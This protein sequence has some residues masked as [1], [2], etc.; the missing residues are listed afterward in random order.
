[1]HLHQQRPISRRSDQSGSHP[2]PSESSADAVIDESGES[3]ILPER[4]ISASINDND[5]TPT[6]DSI[7]N[8]EAQFA[9]VGVDNYPDKHG[10]TIHYNA[11]IDAVAGEADK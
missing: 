9:N 7:F 3:D 2:L 11:R 4:G 8:L 10:E 5:D 1:M 6:A